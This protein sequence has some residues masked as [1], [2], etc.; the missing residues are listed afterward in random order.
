VDVTPRS[1]NAAVPDGPAADEPHAHAAAEAQAPAAAAEWNGALVGPAILIWLRHLVPLT[2]LSAIALSP[3]IAIALATR[4]PADLAGAKTVIRLGWMLLAV[5]WFAQLWL[6]GGAS[7]IVGRASSGNGAPRS[8]LRAFGAGLS[9]MVR[10]LVPCLV[11]A[12][13]VLLG[14]LAL[15]VPGPVLLV[16]LALTAASR[17]RGLP[18]PLFDSIAATRRQLPAVVLAVAALFAI[19]AVIGVVAYRAFMPLPPRP[20]PAQLAAVRDLVRV[21]AAALVLLSPLPATV[22]ALLRARVAP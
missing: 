19:D 11:A 14:C 18:A 2:L 3:L 4:A 22:L 13:A 7:A 16:L 5:A 10:T 6:V 20:T 21:I 8:Q 9:R 17:Q 1:Q 15:V 12:A